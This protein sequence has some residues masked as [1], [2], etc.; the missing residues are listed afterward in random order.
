MIKKFEKYLCELL[1]LREYIICNLHV[2]YKDLP[3]NIQAMINY[4]GLYLPNNGDIATQIEL[5]IVSR[6]KVYFGIFNPGQK[7]YFK[8]FNITDDYKKLWNEKKKLME[9]K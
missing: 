2:K 3:E 6:L 9:E 1:K 5:R 4:Y 8:G 7:D